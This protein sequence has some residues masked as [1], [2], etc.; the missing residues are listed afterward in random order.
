MCR[1]E[2]V[3]S[4]LPTLVAAEWYRAGRCSAKHHWRIG[5]QS[6]SLI[7]Q[8][9][10]CQEGGITTGQATKEGGGTDSRES[11]L[12][13]CF[14]VLVIIMAL[15]GACDSPDMDTL[16]TGVRLHHAISP[17]SCLRLEFCIHSA[18]ITFLN[19]IQNRT[20]C[21]HFHCHEHSGNI[22]QEY[23]AIEIDLPNLATQVLLFDS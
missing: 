12:K 9:D 10:N 1:L 18:L 14:L 16:E 4:C 6:G 23:S 7:F 15:A 21:L 3:L 5:N 8:K 20:L 17:Q 19:M 13:P 22:W 2:S 11:R